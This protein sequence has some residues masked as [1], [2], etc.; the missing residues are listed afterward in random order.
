MKRNKLFALL[1]TLF[2]SGAV[3]TACKP[4]AAKDG[5]KASE[6]KTS[7][8]AKKKDKKEDVVAAASISDN[9]AALEAA[10]KPD[11][12]WII[13]PTKNVTFDHD[14]TVSGKFYDH[15]AKDGKVARK[16]SLY[17]Q[18]KDNK[19]SDRFTMT[20]PKLIVESENF[21]IVNGTFKG[22]ILVKAKGFAI[23]GG[24]VDGTITFASKEL[25]DSAKLDLNGGKHNGEVKVE[26]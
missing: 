15:G 12:A 25:K 17:N 23:D 9:P 22:D 16:F 7:E 20:A 19:V 11:G 2:V 26:K 1:A 5:D 21:S 14:I 13:A 4:D 8:N 18:D 24:T 3:L 10:M 6:P